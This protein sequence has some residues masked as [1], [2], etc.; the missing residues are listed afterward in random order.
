MAGVT[1]KGT[2]FGSE[3]LR[4]DCYLGTEGVGGGVERRVTSIFLFPLKV[5]RPLGSPGT[6]VALSCSCPCFLDEG[7]PSGLQAS[8][9]YGQRETF[10]GVQLAACSQGPGLLR[11]PS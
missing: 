1:E 7:A 10:P 5:W 2:F 8:I 6:T 9:V 3:G 4:D 11:I